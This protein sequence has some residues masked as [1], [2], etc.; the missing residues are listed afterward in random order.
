MYEKRVACWV[1]GI[2]SS[3][4]GTVTRFQNERHMLVNLMHF[5]LYLTEILLYFE[6]ILLK[7]MFSYN[8]YLY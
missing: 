3:L 8:F 4:D 7:C 6:C 5:I 2:F 1:I